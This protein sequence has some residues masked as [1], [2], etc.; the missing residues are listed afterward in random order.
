[1]T[2]NQINSVTVIGAGNV[3]FH[4]AQ[5][6]FS[7]GINVIQIF[8][9]KM[10]NAI[11]CAEKVNTEAINDLEKVK[12]EVDLVV[13]AV[14]DDVIGEVSEKIPVLQNSIIVHTSGSVSTDVLK[15]H[16]HYG[17][18]YPLQTFT[19]N[20]PPNWKN[21]PICISANSPKSEKKLLDLANKINDKT[22]Q[23]ND[24]QRQFL[25]LNAV[26]VNN[27]VNHLM[28]VAQDILSKNEVD[29]DI[30]RPLFEE[31]AKKALNFS[32][33]EIQTGPARRGDIK[34][35]EKHL[36]LLKDFPQYQFLYKTLSKSISSFYL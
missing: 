5:L 29:F 13:L 21:I 34:T 8:S 3:G 33:S 4:L 12:G 36:E 9:R 28:V 18:F 16:P 7:L 2:N 22:Y 17:S 25:H 6:F 23:I 24:K 26:I 14:N 10:E 30:L 1:M 20:T 19:K 31:T 11:F 15:K 32:P 35:I 27:F